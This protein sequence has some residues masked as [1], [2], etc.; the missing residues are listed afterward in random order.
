MSDNDNST[1]TVIVKPVTPQ[2]SPTDGSHLQAERDEVLRAI[3]RQ[4]PDLFLE[5]Y[6]RVRAANGPVQ[7]S[8]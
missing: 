4:Y 7:G 8:E 6:L 5:R 2:A 1:D 3:Y